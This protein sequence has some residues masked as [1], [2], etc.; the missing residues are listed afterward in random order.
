[1]NGIMPKFLIE[2][3]TLI[4]E[5]AN[6]LKLCRDGKSYKD[7]A[8]QTGLSESTVIAY[9]DCYLPKRRQQYE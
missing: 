3:I 1:M 5:G 2:Y 8:N 9:C 7:I 4:K 6:V